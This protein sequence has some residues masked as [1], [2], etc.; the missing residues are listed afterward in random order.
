MPR[1]A[2]ARR[3]GSW[4][5]CTSYLARIGTMN[6]G[7][8]VTQAFEAAGSGDFP[9]AR[10]WS[11]GLESPVNPQAGKPALQAGSWRGIQERGDS[12]RHLPFTAAS[13]APAATPT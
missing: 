8:F 5:A 10:S 7:G 11:T 3:S 12:F 4:V 13:P 9:V 1:R 6:R 2:G